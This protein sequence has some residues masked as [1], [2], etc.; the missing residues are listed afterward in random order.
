[1]VERS[2]KV[3]TVTGIVA[4][5]TMGWTL[6]HEHL[7]LD[8]CP[9]ERKSDPEEPITLENLGR[10]RRHL[11]RNPYNA[12]LEDEAEAIA[13]LREFKAAGGG[14][15][16]EVTSIGLKRDPEGLRRIAEG[17]GVNILMGCSY[18][19]HNYHPPQ[20]ARLGEA[21]IT[22]EIV[23]D[24]RQGAGE[25]GICAGIIGE[26]GLYWPVHKAEV[27]VL[28]ASALAQKE[29][30]APL[31]IHPG[32][33]PAAPLDAIAT[34]KEAGGDPGRTIVAHIDR[35]L[36]RREDMLALAETGCYLEFDLFGYE[37]S[38]YPL[39]PID[40]PNDAV[41]IEHLQ[42]LIAAGHRD[43][44]L[45]AHDVCHKHRLR[46]YGGDGYSHLLENVV[47][48]MRRKGMSDADIEALFVH[49]PARIMAFA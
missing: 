28:R 38:Y 14:T 46:K 18:Y 29:T 30:G 42:A 36:F 12:R 20:V 7:L 5:E 23:R 13:E 34:V 21:A 48:M 22:A 37:S 19:V 49:N 44:L 31:M 24:I 16:V 1:M 4:P 40:M 25:T 47:P 32:R 39:A 41:R 11:G 8:I 17:A 45:V 26:V 15:V 43:Q 9:P 35:T 33:D 27:K 2:G 3:Q 6:A 10:T